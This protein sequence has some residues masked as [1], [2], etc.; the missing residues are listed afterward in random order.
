MTT[1]DSQRFLRALTAD[2][3]HEP[4][5]LMA[6]CRQ[7]TRLLSM[8]GAAVVLMA[9]GA[10]PSV[11]CAHGVTVT[12][13]D[14]ELMLGEGPAGDAYAE[15]RPVLVSDLA[16]AADR[17]PEFARAGAA[18]GIQALY[19][20]PLQFGAAKFGVLVLYQDRAHVLEGQE[21]ASAVLLA[22]LISGLVL[23]LQAGASTDSL[24]QGLQVDDHRAVL[25]QA[26]GMVAVQLDSPVSDAL[27]R[28]RAHAFA[29]GRPIDE[30]AA[31]VVERRL[32]FDRD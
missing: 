22:E 27:V 2:F 18:Q 9:D 13:Q 19:A 24:A 25:H 3:D 32:R 15:G 31:D 7:A 5:S 16:V 29:T 23:D 8:S 10:S 1:E 28:L 6:V 11:A 12:V 20:L 30:V 14:L 17:W 4:L 26:T 21:Y